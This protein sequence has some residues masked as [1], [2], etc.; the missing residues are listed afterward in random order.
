LRPEKLFS[1]ELF[2]HLFVNCVLDRLKPI[3]I[4]PNGIPNQSDFSFGQLA[5]Q[6]FLRDLLK[7]INIYRVNDFF[8]AIF[9]HRC[10]KS[11]QS[12]VKNVFTVPADCIVMGINFV[13]VWQT[14]FSA[15]TSK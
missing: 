9:S 6:N 3:K 2:P 5:F 14:Q 11:E 8:A 15:P 10:I 4:V 12:L 1:S 13:S 7:I